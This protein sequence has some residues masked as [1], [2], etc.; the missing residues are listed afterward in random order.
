MKLN[1]PEVTESQTVLEDYVVSLLFDPSEKL[2]QVPQAELTAVAKINENK[3]NQTRIEPITD[4]NVTLRQIVS[5]IIPLKQKSSKPNKPNKPNKPIQVD[6]PVKGNISTSI[7]KPA[8]VTKVQNKVNSPVEELEDKQPNKS[9]L[10]DEK[11]F[12][13]KP[14][15]N[16]G[17]IDK[18]QSRK[19]QQKHTEKIKQ[20]I[21]AYSAQESRQNRFKD[22]SEKDPRLPG[23]E[24]LLAKIALA[25][26]VAPKE[27]DNESQTSTSVE[28]TP[29][30]FSEVDLASSQASFAHREKQPLKDILGNVFQTLV[31]EVGSLPLA[32]PLVKLGGIVNVSE[33]DITPLVG[34]PDWFMGLVPHEKGNLMVI[35]TQQFLMPERKI[36][37]QRT[38]QYLII[39]DDSMWAL[40]CHSVGDAKNL[41][42]E[43]VRWSMKSS[44]RPWFAGMVV[45]YMSALIEVDRLINMLAE[46]IV[47]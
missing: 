33:Q 21:E 23:V 19:I 38:Y 37:Q 28:I 42:P 34:T 20:E 30:D 26:V 44:R 2:Q 5:D 11:E 43:D 36:D 16:K 10:A 24:K 12:N 4:E 46:N 1:K 35:D 3:T 17:L 31:F 27:Q 39:L 15:Y 22:K 14:A 40:A 45:E 7:S 32:V 9:D 47:D 41:N 13:S 6:A 25:N 8:E 18:E 29:G